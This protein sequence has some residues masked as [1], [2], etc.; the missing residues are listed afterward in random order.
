M[1][2]NVAHKIEITEVVNR[3][4]IHT[5]QKDWEKLKSLVFTHDVWFDMSSAGGGDPKQ[6]TAE[7]ICS[8][9]NQGFQGIDAV[10]HQAGNYLID[11]NGNNA[12]VF[13][14]SVATHYKENTTKGKVRVFTGSY[15]IALINNSEGWRI[16]YFKYKLKFI[17]GNILL[18]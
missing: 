3:L 6:I 7:E 5:D 1:N 8:M 12:D 11:I 15:D 10:H 9:W 4:F 2:P 17:D 13:A 14:Y 16:N 18:D